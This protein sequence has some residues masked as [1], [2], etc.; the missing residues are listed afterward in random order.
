MSTVHLNVSLACSLIFYAFGALMLTSVLALRQIRR[1][2][3]CEG[4][5]SSRQPLL[6]V[7]YA[8]RPPPESVYMAR[9]EL[10]PPPM[11]RANSF[12]ALPRGSDGLQRNFSFRGRPTGDR[13]IANT[14]PKVAFDL[15]ATVIGESP[16]PHRAVVPSANSA[17]SAPEPTIAETALNHLP[18]PPPSMLPPPPSPLRLYEDAERVNALGDMPRMRSPRSIGVINQLNTSGSKRD[19]ANFSMSLSSGSDSGST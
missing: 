19:S 15:R 7:R 2:A 14:E 16:L 17:F 5:P 1:A 12:E 11:R 3:A 8:I 6:P 4:H 9:A 18:P 13:R 10:P